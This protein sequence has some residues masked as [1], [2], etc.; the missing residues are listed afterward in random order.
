MNSSEAMSERI[1]VHVPRSGRM[2]LTL[3]ARLQHGRL[4]LVVPGGQVFSF[5]GNLAGPDATIELRDW[6]VFDAVMRAGDVGFAEAYV[7]RRWHTPDLRALLELMAINRATIE[8]VLYGK[9]WGR[10]F[11]RIRH[12]RRANTRE[13]A[14]K[15][16]HAHYDLGNSFYQ[17]WLDPSMTYSAALFEGNLARTLEQAQQAKYERILRRLDIR[18]DDHILEIGCGWGGFA[19]YAARTR[20]CRVRGIT[21]SA[22]QLEFARRRIADAGLTRLVELSLT[23]YRDIEGS[24][25]HVVSV[26]MFEAVGERF[27]PVFFSVVRDRLKSGGRAMIQTITIADELFSRYRQSIDFVQQ[28]IFPGGMLPSAGIFRELARREGL[29]VRD[30]HCF[31]GDYAETLRRWHDRYRRASSGLRKLGFDDRFERLWQFYLAYC[32]AGFRVGSTDV[33]QVELQRE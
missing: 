13:G 18:A 2:L 5:A 14:R 16:I 26:E 11:Y 25:D 29:I 23:D 6:Q 33:M 15:N 20:G 24:F 21:L 4:N 3:L 1:P 22:A 12:L 31:G 27:W 9:W 28:Y 10:L 30:R 32:E 17:S 8:R 19:E 7:D